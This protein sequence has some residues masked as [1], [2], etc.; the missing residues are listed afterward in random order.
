LRCL[1]I[2]PTVAGGEWNLFHQGDDRRSMIGLK[3]ATRHRV[4][5]FISS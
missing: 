3:T 5:P 2:G 1:E 4:V